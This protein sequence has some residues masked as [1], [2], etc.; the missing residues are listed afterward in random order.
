MVKLFF[1]YFIYFLLFDLYPK[2]KVPINDETKP[3]I[4][5]VE[6]VSGN[7]LS[8]LVSSLVVSDFSVLFTV[9]LFKGTIFSDVS[10]TGVSV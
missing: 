5:D 8:F 2:P 7:S 10:F 9:E 4:T 3:T 1:F 6:L